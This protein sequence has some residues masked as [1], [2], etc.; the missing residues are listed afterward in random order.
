MWPESVR[1]KTW[2]EMVYIT[3]FLH[4]RRWRKILSRMAPDF[5]SPSWRSGLVEKVW[6]LLGFNLP[7][8]DGRHCQWSP[9]DVSLNCLIEKTSCKHVLYQSISPIHYQIPRTPKMIPP[10]GI[11]HW[12]NGWSFGLRKVY[13]YIY[14]IFIYIYIYY[15]YLYAVTIYGW[16]FKIMHNIGQQ[17]NQ[18]LKTDLPEWT[19]NCLLK[20]QRKPSRLISGVLPLFW[21][22]S[23]YT[24]IIP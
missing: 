24:P 19:P 10:P 7:K 13:I 4:A 18:L 23:Q 20:L 17:L 11:L 1:N 14:N 5:H 9:S 22:A 8:P 15:I 3:P 6:I 2:S 16:W 12:M 21:S